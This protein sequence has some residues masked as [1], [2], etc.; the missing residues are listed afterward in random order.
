MKLISEFAKKNDN[1]DTVLGTIGAASTATVI[2][3]LT[4][5]KKMQHQNIYRTAAL[6]G[7]G[8]YLIN[9]MLKKRKYNK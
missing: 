8:I 2:P 1:L 6:G 5:Y 7:A 3:L 4:P 9:K